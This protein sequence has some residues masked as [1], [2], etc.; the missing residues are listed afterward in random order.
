MAITE[1]T[2]TDIINAEKLTG[3]IN[4]SAIPQTVDHINVFGADDV[5]VWMSDVLSGGDETILD[6]LVAAHDPAPIQETLGSDKITIFEGFNTGTPTKDGSIQVERG[7]F[8]NASVRWDET[9]E[10]WVIG[11]LGSEIEVAD[12]DQVN[13]LLG[14]SSIKELSDVRNPMTPAAGDA[15]VWNN[16]NSEWEAGGLTI[17]VHDEGSTQGFFSV[18][19]FIGAGVTVTDGGSG[20]ADITIAGG[21][22]ISKAS[23]TLSS[24]A[25]VSGNT[26][27]ATFNHALGTTDIVVTIWDTASGEQV[28]VGKVDKTDINNVRIEVDGNSES[29]RVVVVG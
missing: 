21:G 29:L 13:G 7:S 23:G 28:Q 17:D 22:G 19:N 27:D 12:I 1:Y 11:Q 6:G 16:G 9:L 4:D 25:V 26:Y 24:W 2:Y 20:E 8:A 5:H 10:T 3:E 18:L 15:L 14:I